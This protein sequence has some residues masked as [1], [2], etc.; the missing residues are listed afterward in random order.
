[1]SVRHAA[2]VITSDDEA[3]RVAAALAPRLAGDADARDAERR[4]PRR[5]LAELAASGLLGITVPH[6]LGGADVRAATAA[7]VLRLLGTADLSLAQIPQPHFAFLNALRL[8]GSAAARERVF[9][10][11]LDG[12]L[13]GNAQS[14]RGGRHAQDHR[15]RLERTGGGWLLNGVKYYA[16]GALFARWIAVAAPAAV[17]GEPRPQAHVAFVRADDPGVRV[18]DDWDGMGQRTTAS[19]TVELTG[20]RVAEPFVVPHY[21]TFREPTTYGAFAQLLH[22]AIDVGAARAALSRAAEFVRTT[23]RPWFESGGERAED[24]PLLVQRFGELEIQVR[25]AEALLAGAADRVDA[26]RAVPDDARTAEASIAVAAARVAGG[27]AAVDLGN[28]LFEVAGTRAAAD[29]LNL[30]RHWRDARTHTLHDPPRWKVQHIG[31]HSLRREAPPRHG[32]L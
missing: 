30:H 18:V 19:G 24:D 9:R 6:P 7:E 31:R 17:P 32:L 4:P 13:V 3:L 1:M 2:H 25:A 28:A 16:T 22:A 23:T 26:A 27:A 21:R 10:D 5:E 11:V 29:R 8:Q 14:E 12:A 20:V 15:T